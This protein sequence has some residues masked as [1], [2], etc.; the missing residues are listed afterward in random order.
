[1]DNRRILEQEYTRW[2]KEVGLTSIYPNKFPDAYL[3]PALRAMAI[4]QCK[5]KR[6]A[7]DSPEWLNQET[8]DKVVEMWNSDN[9]NESV[10]FIQNKALTYGIKM[11]VKKAADII[12]KYCL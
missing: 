1:M 7:K 5:S 12:T 10:S 8:I 4:V 9:K 3:E 6:K 11:G 2:V